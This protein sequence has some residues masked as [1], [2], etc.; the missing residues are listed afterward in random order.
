MIL[1]SP[2]F[3]SENSAGSAFNGR[4]DKLLDDKTEAKPWGSEACP[5]EQEIDDAVACHAQDQR[6]AAR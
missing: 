2:A 4:P 3:Y 6:L 1:R 5:A